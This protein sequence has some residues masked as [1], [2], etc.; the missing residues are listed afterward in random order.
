[1]LKTRWLKI[2]DA[3]FQK[4]YPYKAFGIFALI[5]YPAYYIFW[6]FSD[7][8][9]YEN[10]WFRIIAVLLAIPLV[11]EEK[12]PVKLK[13]YINFYW[14]GVV[15]FCLPFMF[16]YILLKNNFSYDLVLDVFTIVLLT[17]LLLDFIPL[18]II[19]ALGVF[20]GWLLF[21]LLN[22]YPTVT[23][24]TYAPILR[25]YLFTMFFG[26]VFA[27]RKDIIYKEKLKTLRSISVSMA[28]ELRT[29]LRSISFSLANLK[30]YLPKITSP[31]DKS[32]LE[33]IELSVN[34]ADTE[35]K[36]AFT[37]IDMLLVKS[38][39]STI[40]PEKFQSCSMAHCVEEA[41]RR[42]P[43]DIDEAKLIHWDKSDFSFLGDELLMVHI[44]FNLLKNSL[45]YIKGA[46]KGEIKIW[47]ENTEKIN[48][49]HFYDSGKGISAKI[50][51]QI[52]SPFFT[53]TYHGT[54]VGLSFCKYVMRTFNGDIACC[55]VENEFTEF[56]LSFPKERARNNLDS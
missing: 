21:I 19:T 35:L 54:G 16:T 23:S 1:M 6:L 27:H 33:T 12:W 26:A 46:G 34:D 32:D 11:M 30:Q 38:N 47:C 8:S 5:T 48:I 2:K 9:R 42:Y 22:G 50:L 20:L 43:F 4:D 52:F 10:I 24:S 18:I 31:Q 53:K 40:N 39:I 15:M 29:P 3:V 36:S 55:S 49:L 17:I 13:V 56:L 37:V 28:H 25:S 41:M 44:L 45:Y 14:Y 51:A 7:K